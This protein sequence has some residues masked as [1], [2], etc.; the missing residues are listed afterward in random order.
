MSLLGDKKYELTVSPDPISIAFADICPAQ[1]LFLLPA[2]SDIPLAYALAPRHALLTF[3]P[4]VH[5]PV[6]L[7][8]S[9]LPALD[10]L[11]LANLELEGLISV[12][13]GIKLFSIL[14]HA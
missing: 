6:H 1:I 8:N 2:L 9:F 11:L 7:C 3:T 10:H 13:G 12:P 14:Q 5:A 4:A